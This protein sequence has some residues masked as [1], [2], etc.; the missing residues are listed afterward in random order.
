MHKLPSKCF[1]QTINI[2]TYSIGSASSREMKCRIHSPAVVDAL[3]D[4]VAVSDVLLAS[5]T[6]FDV[7]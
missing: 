7:V 5:V 3:T 2:N 4:T 1:L 6:I